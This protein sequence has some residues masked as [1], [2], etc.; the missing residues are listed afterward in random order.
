M[1]KKLPAARE[2]TNKVK[3]LNG[4]SFSYGYTDPDEGIKYGQQ[5]LAL[6]MKLDWKPGIG[7]AD[8]CLGINYYDKSDNIQALSYFSK[9]IDTY[10]ATDDQKM[11]AGVLNNMSPIY[12]DQCNY[13]KALDC[14]FKALKITEETGDKVSNKSSLSIIGNVYFQESD[15]PKALEYYFRS[16]KISEEINDQGGIAANLNGIGNVYA[17]QKEYSKALEY[18]NKDLNIVK[19]T[20][21]KRGIADVNINLGCTYAA[22]NDQVKALEYF[23]IAQKIDEEIRQKRDAA[24]VS[25]NIGTSYASL[26]NYTLALAYEENSLKTAKGIG[27]KYVT[28]QCL[29]AASVAYL[30]IVSEPATLQSGK[31]PSGDQPDWIHLPFASIPKGKHALLCAATDTLQS[32]LATAKEINTLDLIQACYEH[33]AEA[34]K[35][36][37]NYKQALGYADSGRAIKDSIF[38]K[39][40]NIRITN[41]ETK[42]E[43]D[44]KE[45]Q[46]E[47]DHLDLAKKRNERFFFIAA[48]VLLVVVGVL[49]MNR[50]YLKQ[51]RVDAEKKN[52]ESQRYIAEKDKERATHLLNERIKEL[53]TIYMA[54]NILLDENKSIPDVFNEIVNLLPPGWQYPDICADSIVFDGNE[55]TTLNYV[56]SPFKQEA[57]VKTQDGRTGLIEVIYTREMPHEVEGPFLKEE[58]DLINALANI[59]EVY[60]NKKSHQDALVKSEANLKAIFDT[61]DTGYVLVDR[62]LKIIAN[63]KFAA[64][65]ANN[66][67]GVVGD[68]D[69]NLASF[70]LDDR[71]P[72]IEKLIPEVFNGKSYNYDANYPQPDGS[73]H[74]YNVRLYP[75]AGGGKEVFGLMIAVDNITERKNAEEAL[76]KSEA[77]LKSIFDT[78]HVSYLLLDDQFTVLAY[79]Q[80]IMRWYSVFTGITLRVGDNFLDQ[81]R[82][83]RRESIK[84]MYGDVIASSTPVEYETIYTNGKE[85]MYV[86]V[87]VTPIVSNAKTIGIC[88]TGHDITIL[89]KG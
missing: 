43:L 64:D 5:A 33:L 34:Y 1:L 24:I 83:E 72:I 8:N 59:I 55:Y 14:L 57:P 74:W 81:A 80:Y 29:L 66:E 2:D 36:N 39:E 23:F 20:G 35:L 42:R 40:N 88:I 46:I 48:I 28:V 38:S 12:A 6:A 3:L 18:Y 68:I 9:A 52:A 7:R 79:N 70:F 13:T 61:T 84:K 62:K 22:Q 11:I 32:A 89:H 49:F 45:K 54:N 65:F 58:R 76:K 82:P 16:L 73:V 41:L 10:E 75:I 19:E 69:D 63:N 67:I 78:T 44:L 31:I 51:R 4:L 30:G 56:P 77:N 87:T 71:K 53:A 17:I 15:Y 60:F 85:K 26:K 27:D 86:M 37:G 47:L 50:Q 25:L 21:N